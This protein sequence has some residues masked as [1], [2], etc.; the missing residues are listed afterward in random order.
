MIYTR[1]PAQSM[2]DG[3]RD[4]TVYIIINCTCQYFWLHGIAQYKI[5][6]CFHSFGGIVNF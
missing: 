3:I 2:N 4:T 6:E 1:M 5:Y